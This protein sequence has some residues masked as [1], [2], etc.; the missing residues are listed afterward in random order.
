MAHLTA[1]MWLEEASRPGS[2]SL[3]PNPNH[4]APDPVSSPEHRQKEDGAGLATSSGLLQGL[5]FAVASESL[6]CARCYHTLSLQGCGVDFTGLGRR[7]NSKIS[8]SVQC[9]WALLGRG[10]RSVFPLLS[11]VT[12][13]TI[14]RLLRA[15][16]GL[17]LP[18]H[19]P[20]HPCSSRALALARSAL[21]RPL[22][23]PSSSSRCILRVLPLWLPLVL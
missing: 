8:F 14:L 6:L 12:Q 19:D 5:M 3:P 10:P 21:I 4:P 16:T 11:F 9:S 2:P 15:R 7:G 17:L 20:T 13:P 18:P 1:Y 23:P 22:S